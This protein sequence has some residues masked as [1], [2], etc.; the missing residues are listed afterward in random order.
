VAKRKIDP[1]LRRIQAETFQRYPGPTHSAM[2][3]RILAS[4]D[5]ETAL[6]IDNIHRCLRQNPSAEDI[7]AL[8]WLRDEI[9]GLISQREAKREAKTKA[10]LHLQPQQMPL[11]FGPTN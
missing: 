2:W 6:T 4:G 3:V 8:D 9:L 10:H 11:D 5:P 1:G 7:A